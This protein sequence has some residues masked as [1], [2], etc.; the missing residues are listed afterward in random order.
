[1]SHRLVTSSSN[2]RVSAA[3]RLRRRSQRE[4][5]GLIL[6]EGERVISDALELGVVEDLFVTP[7][8]GGV[9][10]AA[11]ERDVRP[12]WVSASVL[13]SLSE[14]VTPQGAV[15]IVRSPLISATDISSWSLVLVLDQVRDPGNAGTLLRAAVAAGASAVIFTEGSVDATNPKTVRASAGALFRVPVAS[16]AELEKVAELAHGA[17]AAMVGAA[18]EAALSLYEAD[19][20]VPLAVVVSNEAHGLSGDRRALLDET[21]SIPMPGPQESLNVSIAGAL[22]LFEV[23]RQRLYA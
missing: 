8:A 13:R 1:M 17:G 20:R 2:P 16:G 10:S 7:D 23:V 4:A 22:V 21:V 5:T 15:A 12:L 14:A 3:R 18:T 11:E 9:A 6:V 19:L